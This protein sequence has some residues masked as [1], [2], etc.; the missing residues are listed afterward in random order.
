VDLDFLGPLDEAF[1]GERNRTRLIRQFGATPL[2]RFRLFV[3]GFG[4]ALGFLCF[5]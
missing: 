2:K 3:C 5:C 1:A 4:G